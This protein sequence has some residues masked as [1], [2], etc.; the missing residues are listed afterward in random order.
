M[1]VLREFL[2][3]IIES[4]PSR[5]NLKMST[6]DANS[7]PPS[8]LDSYFQESEADGE[9]ELASH[10]KHAEDVEQLEYDPQDV[11]GPIPAYQEKTVVFPDPYV[12]GQYDNVTWSR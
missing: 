7:F 11:R 9:L 5:L 4:S 1:E 6:L 8:H 10:L 3:L 2:R 12:R